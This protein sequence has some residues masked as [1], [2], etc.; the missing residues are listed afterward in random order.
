[1]APTELFNNTRKE[2]NL[3]TKLNPDTAPKSGKGS[4]T[5]R[6]SQSPQ[7]IRRGGAEYDDVNPDPVQTNAGQLNHD[8]NTLTS[9]EPDPSRAEPL[10]GTRRPCADTPVSTARLPRETVPGLK[11][12]SEGLNEEGRGCPRP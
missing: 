5:D 9:K 4:D 11:A 7:S 6:L 10:I 8:R 1:M 3:M 12:W 2:R